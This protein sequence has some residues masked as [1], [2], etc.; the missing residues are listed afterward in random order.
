MFNGA[1][2]VGNIEMNG[3]NGTSWLEATRKG[4]MLPIVLMLAVAAASGT[5]RITEPGQNDLLRPPTAPAPQ[6]PPMPAL[7][8][9][10][11]ARPSLRSPA[12]F[13]PDMP[14]SQAIDILRN[15]TQPPLNL[16][17]LW[18][19][20]E[21]NAGID[22]NTPIGIDGLQRIRLRQCLD[23]LLTS[24]SA[25]AITRVS[26]V[27]QNGVITVATVDSLP[28]P[29][30][31]TRVY[32]ISDLVAPPSVG[33]GFGMMRGMMPGMMPGMGGGMSYGGYGGSG[34]GGYTPGYGGYSPGYGSGYG[35]YGPTSGYSP[36]GGLPGFTGSYRGSGVYGR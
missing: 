14:F 16:V 1:V 17:V 23:I 2:L 26:Y 22:R 34:I 18:R 10:E 27:V 21:E 35:N 3:S 36:L 12:A 5:E 31:V 8:R 4:R 9:F 6:E 19:E 32:D 7:P 11:P 25:S 29:K 13:T 15:S 20:L 30:R 33:M 24:I 28:K